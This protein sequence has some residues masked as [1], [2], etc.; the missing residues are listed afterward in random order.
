MPRRAAQGTRWGRAG[1]GAGAGA[2]R[3]S[4]RAAGPRGAGGA[5]GPRGERRAAPSA[6]AP[7][8]PAAVAAQ[9][10]S[11]GGRGR[12][13]GGSG[14]R[15]RLPVLRPPAAAHH[16]R[17]PAGRAAGPGAGSAVPEPLQGAGRLPRAGLRLHPEEAVRAGGVPERGAVGAGRGRGRGR[18]GPAAASA[19]LPGGDGDGDGDGPVGPGE[20]PR[21]LC[22][23]SA[24]PAG[25]EG[26]AG[27]RLRHSPAAGPVL[28]PCTALETAGNR[29][30]VVFSLLPVSLVSGMVLKWRVVHGHLNHTF[31]C[32]GE[33]L[34]L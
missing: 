18:G 29:K 14:R 15:R 10:G 28:K 6:R 13:R 33:I 5:A 34:F 16:L 12:G 7:S 4:G 26:T 22:G 11:D 17:A 32:D 19:P 9:H 20:A 8:H 24:A 1:A 2:G 25:P 31:R 3:G 27:W 21:G 23:S 30:K